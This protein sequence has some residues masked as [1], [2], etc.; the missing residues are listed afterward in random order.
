MKAVAAG[1]V[2]GAGIGALAAST[3]YGF[4]AFA[5]ALVFAVWVGRRP[6]SRGAGMPRLALALAGGMAVIAGVA[7]WAIEPS[8]IELADAGA[9]GDAG[10]GPTDA[11]V[12]DARAVD[13][14]ASPDVGPPEDPWVAAAMER[15]RFGA[16]ADAES[17]LLAHQGDPHAQTVE[18]AVERY[19]VAAAD[20]EAWLDAM[21][22]KYKGSERVIIAGLSFRRRRGYSLTIPSLVRIGRLTELAMDR[23]R[24]LPVSIEVGLT[25][26]PLADWLVEE[27][28]ARRPEIRWCWRKAAGP[29]DVRVQAKGWRLRLL[30][31]GRSK[32]EA[33]VDR[34]LKSTRLPR[35]VTNPVVVP[36]RISYAVSAK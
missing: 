34:A 36:V 35:R 22:A 10:A 6:A 27:I 5:A 19:R 14:R 26:E 8:E 9:V 24:V 12:V 17:A 31:A 33:C 16:L 29:D 15:I 3:E 23:R 32:S 4:L 30:H 28:E 7:F 2:L 21:R 18:R 11:A 13:A 20:A 1:L 25:T